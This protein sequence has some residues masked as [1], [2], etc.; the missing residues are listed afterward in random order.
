MSQSN[1]QQNSLF[2]LTDKIQ[3]VLFFLFY[4][5][6]ILYSCLVSV[7][8]AQDKIIYD[9]QGRRDPFMALVTPD[10]RLLNLEPKAAETKIFLG[11]IYY[12]E[13][14]ES[15]AI[16]NGEVV[17][18][19]DYIFGHTVFSIDKNKVVLIKDEQPVEYILEKEEL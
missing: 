12:A 4:S 10:G 8:F 9:D 3:I 6:F 15:Y 5:L 13:N 19:G 2:S 17:S 14:G 11:G 18:V 16:I 7:S 1:D